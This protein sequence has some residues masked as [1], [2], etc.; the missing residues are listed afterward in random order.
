MDPGS[1]L[2]PR[3]SLAARDGSKDK[4]GGETR[5]GLS[6]KIIIRTVIDIRSVLIER[7]REDKKYPAFPFY[8]S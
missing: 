1:R 2:E 7:P 5:D 8:A 4:G 3:A 6:V